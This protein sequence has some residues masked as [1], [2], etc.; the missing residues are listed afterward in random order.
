MRPQDP[1]SCLLLLLL[2][3]APGLLA[4]RPTPRLLLTAED[5]ARI[6]R[7]A[8]SATWAATAR[9]GILQ[10][11]ENWPAAHNQRYGL[12]QWQLPPEGGQW[13]LWYICKTHGVYLQYRAPGQNICPV[14]GQ[15]WTGWPYD[16]VIY[17]RRHSESAS[18]ARDNALAYRLTGKIQFAQAAAAILLAYAE[19][20]SSYPI[21][22]TNNRLNATSGGRAT[23][24]TLDEAGWLIP[25]AWAYDLVADSGLLDAGQRAHIEQDLLRAA[26]AIITRNNAGM[27]NWQSWHNAAIGAVGFALEDQALI[28]KALDDP[29]GGFRFQMRQS[30]LPDGVWYEGAWGYHF[31]AL[32]PLCQLAEMAARGG[33][34]LY[35]ELPLRR[36][37][38]T[39]LRLALPDWSLPNFSDSGN[40]SLA[41]YQRLYEIAYARYGD[42]LLA[43]LLGRQPRGREALFWGAETLP[44]TAPP[45]LASILLEDS[46]N[47]VLRAAL[48]DHYLALKFGPH[49]GGHGH[50]DKLNLISYARGGIMAVDPGTQSYAATTH[51][52]WDK[53]TV[54]HNT[55]VVD[56]QTQAEATGHVHAFAA[57]PSVSA[58]RA[59][60]GSAY[61]QAALARTLIL[62]PEYILDL[63]EARSN[64]GAEHRFDW[65]YH[66]FG[67]L[68]TPLSLAPYSGFPNTNGYQH[69]SQARAATTAESWQVDFDANELPNYGSTWPNLSEIRATFQYSRDQAASGMFSGRMGYD[70][71]AAQGYILFSTPTLSE[72]PAEVPARLSVMLYGDNSGHRLALRL[73]DSTDERFVYSVG[74]VNWTGWRRIT[75]SDPARWSSHYLGDDDGVFDTPVKSV[76]VELT[77]VAG[78]PKQGALYID[79]ILLEFPASGEVKVTDFERTL[80][81]LRLWMQGQPGTTVVAGQGLGPDLLKPVPFVMARRRGTETQF[82]AVLEPYGEAPRITALRA[83]AAGWLEVTATD[84]EDRIW[85][86]PAGGLAFIRRTQGALRRLG[87]AGLAALDDRGQILLQVDPPAPVEVDFSADRATLNVLVNE[88]PGGELRVLAPQAQHITVNGTRIDFRRDGDY[89]LIPLP[90]H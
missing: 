19:V 34:D 58:V 28:A 10:A 11:A 43:G 24:Q 31:Y 75:A 57:L 38:D 50:Y 37:F 20:Y 88:A 59:S 84:F 73:Y 82:A 4:D 9:T 47:A 6:E 17:A 83:P 7:L 13:T 55:V 74:P 16:Q 32:D 65:V 81:N 22:D 3:A 46:G 36:M 87:L 61:K 89:C 71:S 63:F 15:N 53:V 18:A 42:P 21:K 27:S 90:A 33:L 35:A 14:D 72:P 8:Q 30:V 69:L 39:P 40:V 44:E 41:S 66:N 25:L 64:D 52:T 78:G 79:D 62:T 45:A 48:S 2:L 1:K 23:A 49:G 77:S 12:A 86:D 60:A 29:K 80:R 51:S 70:F 68:S 26:V 54:A 56:E 85:C 5:F 67:Q 76:A